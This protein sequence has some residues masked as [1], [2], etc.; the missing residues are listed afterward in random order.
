MMNPT[1]LARPARAA[2]WGLGPP[3]TREIGSLARR[4]VTWSILLVVTRQPIGLASTAVL[5]RLLTPGEYGLI[6]MAAV[7]TA[8]LQAF[9]DMGLSLATVRREGLTRAQV[10]NL[11]WINSAA[12]LLLWGACILAGPVLAA[13]FG[14]E[15]LSGVAA[16][17]GAT[18]AIGGLAAQPAALLARQFRSRAIFGVESA[19]CL[20]GAMAAVWLALRGYGYWAL[21]GQALATQLARLVLVLAVT[22]YRPGPP[23]SGEGTRGLLAF[24]GYLTAYALVTYI[25]R[26]LDNILIGRFWGPAALG[27][28][29]RAYFLMSLPV[30]LATSA[31]SGVMVPVLATLV[32]DRKRMGRA[33]RQAA[34]AISLIGLPLA[35]LLLVAAPE[36][37]RLLYGDRWTAVVPLL[38]W[39]A[40]AGMAQTL[41]ASS[42]W[43]YVALG[44]GRALLLVGSALT[45]A[46][47]AA[48]VVGNSWGPRG[49]AVAYTLASLALALPTLLV[50]HRLASLHLSETLREVWPVVRM[51]AFAMAAGLAAGEYVSRMTDSWEIHLAAKSAAGALAVLAGGACLYRDLATGAMAGLRQ[52]AAGGP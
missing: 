47:S 24:G 10:D 17:M 30:M 49:V 32:H 25:G 21:V 16:A 35:G 20:A 1:V 27:Y 5:S 13:F 34:R 51:T 41:V 45:A 14:R 15:A 48:I 33:Y 9:A 42:G 52:R 6:G 40:L 23:R 8:F 2:R 28:Y 36:V 29:A 19:A 12:G 38:R 44:H 37:V 3:P 7:L 39:L 4:G 18:F 22:G 50:A 11:F 46:H 31:L 26:N 43:L